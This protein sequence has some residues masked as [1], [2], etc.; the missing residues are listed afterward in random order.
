MAGTHAEGK[1]SYLS[2]G[3]FLLKV[4][5]IKSLLVLQKLHEFYFPKS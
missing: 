5:R 4:A 2:K 1:S 3:K